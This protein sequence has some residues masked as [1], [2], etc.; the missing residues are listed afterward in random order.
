MIIKWITEIP[1][2]TPLHAL[3]LHQLLLL[4]SQLLSHVAGLLSCLLFLS[5]HF[6]NQ[7]KWCCIELCFFVLLNEMITGPSMAT[8]AWIWSSADVAMNPCMHLH[9]LYSPVCTML[10]VSFWSKPNGQRRLYLSH[11]SEPRQMFIAF[12]HLLHGN[13]NDSEN[14]IIT[15]FFLCFV[16]SLLY[17]IMR[18][19]ISCNRT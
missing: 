3:L 15:N 17:V 19:P 5:F 2:C 11:R 9:D 1:L 7:N 4:P 14:I 12:R 16:H 8:F 10:L 13:T 18:G 6:L